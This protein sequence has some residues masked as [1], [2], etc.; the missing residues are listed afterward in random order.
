MP[1]DFN[2][3]NFLAFL[4]KIPKRM[5]SGGVIQLCYNVYNFFL[6]DSV[7]LERRESTTERFLLSHVINLDQ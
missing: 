4:N 7:C 6:L 1:F 3:G 5:T 2:C